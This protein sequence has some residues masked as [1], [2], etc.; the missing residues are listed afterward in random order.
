MSE[1]KTSYTSFGGL[2]LYRF[3]KDEL[4]IQPVRMHTD[5]RDALNCSLC[6]IYTGIQRHASAVLLEQMKNTKEDKVQEE[7]GDLIALCK[8]GALVLESRN[9]DAM[10]RDFGRLLNEGWEI[11]RKLSSSISSPAID[12]LYDE[13]LRL[14]AYGG[15]LC[16]AGSGGFML[17]LASEAVQDKLKERFKPQNFVKV[18]IEDSGAQI[19][20]R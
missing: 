4:S 2:N 17:F 18:M 14:G 8:E 20:V 5:S 12:E 10:L 15:K 9:S 7:L 16:G 3:Y 19:L 11:K 1:F 6:L 13:A